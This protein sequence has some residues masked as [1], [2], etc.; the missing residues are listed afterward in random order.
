MERVKGL[1][2]LKAKMIF[3]YD[4][5]NFNSFHKYIDRASNILLVVETIK[6]VTVAGFY[7]GV[8]TK[9][10]PMTKPGLLISL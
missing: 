5:F 4:S 10:E 1:N 6:G 2:F 7:S 9:A 8:Y 3:Q